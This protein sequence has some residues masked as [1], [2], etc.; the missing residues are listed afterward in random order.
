MS[1]KPKKA[2]GEGELPQPKRAS[3]R[4]SKKDQIISLFL[5][6][7][8]EVEDI[9]IITGSRPSYVGSV[10]QEAGLVQGYFDLYTS[11][12]HPQ[13][14]YSKF[15]AGKLGFKDEET[16]R[17]SVELIDRLYRQFEFAGDRA[18]QH[19]ALA[20]AL[21]MFDRARWTNKGR[22]AE[23]FQS[24]LVSRL[25]EAV[26]TEGDD[27]AAGETEEAPDELS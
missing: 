5:S 8:G 25:G 27:E 17:R 13:N 14:V 1:S 22:E 7:M 4:P 21:T 10:L 18:G 9:A 12:A 20:M 11:T 16:A 24:W 19:H 23:I 26:V 3:N 6:G 15:F 2:K